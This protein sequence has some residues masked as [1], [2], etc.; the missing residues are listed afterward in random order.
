MAH[1]QLLLLFLACGICMGVP[2]TGKR[3]HL[4]GRIVG[5]KEVNIKDFPFQVSLQRS[6]HSCGGS[7]IGAR[8]VLTA[9]HCT[10]TSSI[11]SYKVR[12]G[13]TYRDSGGLLI[14]IKAV[15]SHPKY[16]SSIIDY[17]FAVLHLEDYDAKNVTQAFVNLP[18]QN[19]TLA[20][21]T[22]V[23]ISGWG[24]TQNV[25]ESSEKLRAVTVPTVNQTE[26]SAAYQNF[27]QITERMLCA[28]LVEGGKD[29]CQGD[30]GGP[31]VANN[32]Q[33]G[34]VSWGYGCARPDFPGVY[35]RVAAVRD[36]IKEVSGI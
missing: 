27:G 4:D 12:I 11:L 33:W 10:D 22:E 36:W 1:I 24:N 18:E 13:S 2:S 26:C 15:H 5:G 28:G 31:L 14:G 35:S 6:Y 8:Y 29:A 23:T 20:V 7:L 25:L 17:D 3:P 21:G 19:E 32:K 30:S 16:D 34:V 9:A